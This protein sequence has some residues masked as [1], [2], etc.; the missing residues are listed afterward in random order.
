M[1]A[2]QQCMRGRWSR[3]CFPRTLRSAR[4]PPAGAALLGPSLT[5]RALLRARLHYMLVPLRHG[6]PGGARVR[7]VNFSRGSD[8][9]VGLFLTQH[10]S[11][12]LE[13]AGLG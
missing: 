9:F 3:Q 10:S 12:A 6:L 8:A 4:P 2:A 13:S 5:Q 7:L 1:A 11:C